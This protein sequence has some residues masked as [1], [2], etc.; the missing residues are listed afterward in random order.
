M[1]E[2]LQTLLDRVEGAWAAAL[3]TLDGLLVEGAKRR[4]VDLEAAIAEHAAL[5]RQAGRAYA[6]SLG[7]PRVEELLVH[8]GHVVGYARMVRGG[9]NVNTGDLFLLLLLPPEANLGQARLMTGWAAER[10]LEAAWRT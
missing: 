10:I 6:Q 8:G 1:E 2:V 7:S 9:P 4:R 5:L 3:G